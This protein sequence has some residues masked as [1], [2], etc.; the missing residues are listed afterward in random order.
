VRLSP[1]PIL[2]KRRRSRARCK[3]PMFIHELTSQ[4]RRRM[5]PRGPLATTPILTAYCPPAGAPARWRLSLIR[6]MGAAFTRAKVPT[7]AYPVCLPELG[8]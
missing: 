3:R 4:M 7:T 5:R 6:A 1:I 2:M 8:A